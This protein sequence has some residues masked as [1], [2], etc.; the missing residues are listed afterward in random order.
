VARIAGVPPTPGLAS[1]ANG[2]ATRSSSC[3]V[4]ELPG[5]DTSEV[6]ALS[7]INA[8][9]IDV[10]GSAGTSLVAINDHGA[11]LGIYGDDPGFTSVHGFLL[12]GDRFT[13]FDL[14]GGAVPLVTDLNNRGQIVGTSIGDPADPSTFHGFLLARGPGGPLTTIEPPGAPASFVG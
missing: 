14:P 1:Y 12:E 8:R 3:P 7:S 6:T 5:L 11:M 9:G 4:F 10:P 13:S 2:G